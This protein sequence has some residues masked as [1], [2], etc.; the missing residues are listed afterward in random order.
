MSPS[1]S[2]SEDGDVNGLPPP[3]IGNDAGEPH[4]PHEP[5]GG[6]G[7][8]PAGDVVVPDVPHEDSADP[9]PPPPPPVDFAHHGR[10]RGQGRHRQA[11]RG[12]AHRQAPASSSR[13]NQNQAFE[14]DGREFRNLKRGGAALECQVHLGEDCWKDVGYGQYFQLDRAECCR[15]LLLWEQDIFDDDGNVIS[16]DAHVARGGRLLCWYA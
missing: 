4:E 5:G 16:R 3:G 6:N 14:L 15:R 10:G 8:P 1:H 9:P 7:L 12:E 13:S 11:G 2:E